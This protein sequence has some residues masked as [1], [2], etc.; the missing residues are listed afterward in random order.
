M[1]GFEVFLAKRFWKK[2][3]RLVLSAVVE[4][5]L[6][7]MV[8]CW[9][10]TGGVTEDVVVVVADRGD[11]VGLAGLGLTWADCNSSLRKGKIKTR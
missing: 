9:G 8:L 2:L 11:E 6:V 3:L 10:L 4:L 1:A 5:S 7:G